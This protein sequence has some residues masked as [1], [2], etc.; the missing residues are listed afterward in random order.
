MSHAVEQAREWARVRHALQ[1]YGAQSY[2]CH[3]DHVER[4]AAPYG[5]DAR[6][7]AQLHDILEDTATRVE[8]IAERFGPTIARAVML[9]T[10]PRKPTRHERKRA[11]NQRL[12]ALDPSDEAAWLALVVKTCDRL[13]NVIASSEHSPPRFQQYQREHGGFRVAVYRPGLCDNL[14]AELDGLIDAGQQ[15]DRHPDHQLHAS[16]S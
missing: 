6:I 16:I 5:E 11:L 13:A 4:I 3:L 10:D 7:V 1:R 15:A 9:V 2:R 14:W 8:E 12:I